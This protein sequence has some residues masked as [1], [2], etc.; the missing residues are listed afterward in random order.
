MC[1]PHHAGACVQPAPVPHVTHID[2][3]HGCTRCLRH[4]PLEPLPAPV[5]AGTV[6]R[7][8]AVAPQRRSNTAGPRR[9]LLGGLGLWGSGGGE[10]RAA[11][12]GLMMVARM[13]LLHEGSWRLLLQRRNGALLQRVVGMVRCRLLGRTLLGVLIH[14]CLRPQAAQGLVPG[15]MWPGKAQSD[16]RDPRVGTASCTCP[17]KLA[18]GPG[19]RG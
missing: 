3:H 4:L 6:P 2:V 19:G 14:P 9:W 10:R 8:A 16:P 7:P 11:G 12:H 5:L 13:R 15:V 18:R 1:R 17:Y